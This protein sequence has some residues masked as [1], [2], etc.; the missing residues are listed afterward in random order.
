[1]SEEYL[2]RRKDFLA[3]NLLSRV[4]NYVQRIFQ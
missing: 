1:M 3:A 4:K 2:N